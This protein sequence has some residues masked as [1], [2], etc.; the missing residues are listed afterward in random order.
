[1]EILLRD[2]HF[3]VYVILIN[4]DERLIVSYIELSLLWHLVNINPGNSQKL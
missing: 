3:I 4:H 2:A 1:M